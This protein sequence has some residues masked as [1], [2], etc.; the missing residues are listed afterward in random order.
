ML[1]DW[2]DVK[3]ACPSGSSPAKCDTLAA[4]NAIVDFTAGKTGIYYA[5]CILNDQTL[6][7]YDATD[8]FVTGGHQPTD[9]AQKGGNG[10]P[11][12]GTFFDPLGF[13][14]GACSDGAGACGTC[15]HQ[16]C[17]TS[18]SVTAICKVN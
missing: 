1:N 4:Y 5:N 3:G 18:Y 17:E 15:M 13:S 10:N 8:T 7:T 12:C 2:G 16:K 14:G 11:G 6:G 9:C